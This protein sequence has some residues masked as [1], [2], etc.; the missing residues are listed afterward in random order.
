MKIPVR[1]CVV[2]A[3]QVAAEVHLPILSRIKG[4]SIEGICDLSRPNA[5][6][7]ASRFNI[8]RVYGSI[9]EINPTDVDILDICTPP[10]SHEQL[11]VKAVEAGFDCLVEKP[12]SVTGEECAVMVEAA[13]KYERRLFPIQNYSFTPAMLKAKA[14]IDR[15][16]VGQVVN[17][18][19]RYSASF[20][21]HRHRYFLDQAHWVHELPG[22]VF[23]DLAIHAAFALVEIIGRPGEVK[24]VC[25]NTRGTDSVL[26]SELEV[27]VAT[28]AAVG[29]FLLSFGS[30]LKLF[31]ID[32]GGTK[33]GLRVDGN[34]QA[35]VKLNRIGNSK[36][37]TSRGL[38]AA[39]EILQLTR[40]LLVVGFNV[41]TR[42]Y[43]TVTYGHEFLFKSCVRNLKFNE[44]YPVSMLDVMDATFLCAR[45]FR[46][47]GNSI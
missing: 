33:G 12:F 38:Q 29:S 11:V 19:V 24:A 39:N 16:E 46:Q 41:F 43:S 17:A 5:E 10:Q 34:S 32:I 3:G 8:A 42:R 7:L 13:R 35:V 44:P 6:K 4:I 22:D 28:E 2:G 37:I 21:D 23:S 47:L 36:S 18:T 27:I 26:G 9:D 40:N 25:T 15:G 1:V 20:D 31:T 45:A 14:M 30:A